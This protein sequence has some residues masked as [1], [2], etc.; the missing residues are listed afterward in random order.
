[1][2]TSAAN[3]N[4]TVP[5]G[6]TG[7]VQYNDGTSYAGTAGATTDGTNITALNVK[8]GSINLKG[9][10]SGTLVFSVPATVTGHTLI[11]PAAIGTAGQVLKISDAGTGQ[12][13]WSGIFPSQ[14]T[15]DGKSLTTNGTVTSWNYPNLISFSASLNTTSPNNTI[16]AS[17]IQADKGSTHQDFVCGIKGDGAFQLQVA[18]SSTTGGDK[19][20]TNSVDLQVIRTAS[21]QVASG[22][23][24]FVSGQ[25]N[26][27]SNYNSVAMGDGNNSSNDSSIALGKNNISSQTQSV[28]L[29]YGNTASGA[30]SFAAG[31]SNQATQSRAISLGFGNVSSGQSSFTAGEGCSATYDDSVAIGYGNT[32]ANYQAF[33]IG[34]ESYARYRS[35]F[36]ISAGKFAAVGDSQTSVSVLHI[37]TTNN[38]PTVLLSGGNNVVIPSGTVYAF[39]ARVVGKR[40]DSGTDVFHNTIQGTIANNGGTTAIQGTNVTTAITNT[41]GTWAATVVANDTADS[42]EVTVTGE[43]GATIRWV[44]RLTLVEVAS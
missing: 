13:E 12:L 30:Y 19:R 42:I 20:G 3:V 38:T 15:N 14:A 40:T 2:S 5:G 36:A 9:S 25:N 18:D 35:Q 39:E 44:T 27:A 34:L 7:Q 41:A 22:I 11:L 23:S 17:V 28:A 32:A 29:G 33:A 31:Q 6:T 16:N 37:I 43:T 8:P 24:C 1:M 4:N 26:T 10:T 21:S